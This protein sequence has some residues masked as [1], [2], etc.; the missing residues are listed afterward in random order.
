MKINTKNP[1][2]VQSALSAVNGTARAHTYTLATEILGLAV[3]ADRTRTRLH[4]TKKDALGMRC[5]YTSGD[6]VATAY[7]YGRIVTRVTLEYCRTGWFLVACARDDYRGTTGGDHESVILTTS[8]DAAAV[9]KLRSQ[10][11]VSMLDQL[12]GK[13]AHRP[14]PQ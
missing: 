14:A 1:A 10:Y 5:E 12:R 8:N 11:T 13:L 7:K 3:L 4:L 6:A 9:A 2:K